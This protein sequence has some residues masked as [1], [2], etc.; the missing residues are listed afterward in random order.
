M[1]PGDILF[2]EFS[3]HGGSNREVVKE[4]EFGGNEI[5]ENGILYELNAMFCVSDFD[6]RNTRRIRFRSYANSNGDY[7]YID[8]VEFEDLEESGSALI[9][10]NDDDALKVESLCGLLDATNVDSFM[11][12]LA[13][14]PCSTV[15]N[16]YESVASSVTEAVEPCGDDFGCIVAAES[17]VAEYLYCLIECSQAYVVLPNTTTPAL[18]MPLPA[19]GNH[20]DSSSPSKIITFDDSEQGYGKWWRLNASDLYDG[21]VPNQVTRIQDNTGESTLPL[22]DAHDVS[23][24]DAFLIWRLMGWILE[25]PCFLSIRRTAGR[26]GRL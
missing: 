18:E 9:S 21:D 17:N 11:C 13:L 23:Q 20:T 5:I 4:W 1:D 8:N 24:Y 16:C 6:F 10:V 26:T 12:N 14:V 3:S 19:D 15:Q 25:I 7:F 22:K 2:L